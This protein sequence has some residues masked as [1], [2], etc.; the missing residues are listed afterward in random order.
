[1]KDAKFS[2]AQIMAILRQ[3]ETGV[4]V[5]ELCREHGMS[6]ASFYKWRAKFGGMDASLMSEM[7]DMAEGNR[8]L[9]RM[10]AEMSMQND[11][12]KEALG[13]KR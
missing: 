9:K 6:S 11:L 2:D 12:L 8:R 13:K 4:P 10:Y 3:A 1:M 7:K 5:S